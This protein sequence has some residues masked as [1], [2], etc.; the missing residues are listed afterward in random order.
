MMQKKEEEISQLSEPDFS[1]EGYT[2]ANL[3]T[4][5]LDEMVELIKGKI[6]K[7]NTPMRL[8]QKVSGALFYKLYQF[9]EGKSC[10]VYDAPFD[11]RL[12]V[13]GKKDHQ[14]NTVVQ[15]DICVICD[16][17]KLDAAGCIG[18][19]DLVVEILSI[20]NNRK[21]LIHKY[22]VYEES[23]VLEY[24]VI[25]PEEQTLIIYKLIEG[26]FSPSRLF[27][28]GDVVTTTCLPGFQLDLT[29]I[30]IQL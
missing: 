1:L 28:T 9:L 15:P 25:Q 7:M 8:H 2:Y 18:A 21:E 22:E 14:I 20:G 19:P 13:K 26:K 11:V 29:D 10:E 24:W 17:T 30:L 5:N 12:P 3:L 16:P 4:W 23:G 27:T 6:Y